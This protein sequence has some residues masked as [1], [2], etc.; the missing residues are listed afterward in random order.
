MKPR[1]IYLDAFPANPGDIDYSALQAVGDLQAFD[2]TPVSDIPR[3]VGD[4]SIV[5]TNKCQLQAP[6]LEKLAAASGG[7]VKYIGVTA[8]GTNIVDLPAAR[9]LGITVTNVPGYSTP[10]VAQLV[11][12]LLLELTNHTSRHARAVADG[13]WSR[14][15]DF[16]F[17]VAP[18]TELAGK[19]FGVV[20]MGT[21]GKQVAQIASALG[22]KIAASHQ[23]SSATTR[24]PGIDIQWLSVDELFATAD[25]ISL[26]CPLTDA[27]KHLVNASRL[28]S[29]KPSAILINTGR[30]PLIDEGALAN[31]LHKKQIAGAGLD[32]LSAEPPKA[33]NPL[34]TAP[35]C[36]IT[37]HV[38]W[39]SVEARKRLLQMTADNI[40]AFLAGAPT[41][42]VN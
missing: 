4:A 24:I 33:D 16:C 1:I 29:M 12:A 40:K 34:L 41:N 3:V 11:F 19:T 5:L 10:S 13:G 36:V 15:P 30:G 32:V 2:R 38:A 18:I 17:T 22:M 37:P 7:G 27:T 6:T 26:H 9:K 28:A 39:A 20:G 14:S 25:V 31:A 23:R 8:T 42:V 21:I 35:N